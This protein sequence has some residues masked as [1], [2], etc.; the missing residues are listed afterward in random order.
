MRAGI[1]DSFHI[2]GF[3]FFHMDFFGRQFLFPVFLVLETRVFLVLQDNCKY[4]NLL[5]DGLVSHLIN[6]SR[7]CRYEIL[8]SIGNFSIFMEFV[9]EEYYFIY[10]DTNKSS[11]EKSVLAFS[12]LFTIGKENICLFG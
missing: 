7:C 1:L 10:Q 4:I 9:E 8:V 12:S 3:L 2:N 11:F 6:Y 5:F